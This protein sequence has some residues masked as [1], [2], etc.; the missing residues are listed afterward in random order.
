MLNITIDYEPVP[1]G[2]RGNNGVMNMD[3][4]HAARIWREHGERWRQ[5]YDV[6]IT[7]DTAPVSRIFLEEQRWSD[8]RLIIWVCNRFDYH[9]SPAEHGFPDPGYYDVMGRAGNG[10]L[11]TAVRLVAN[12]EFERRYAAVV[13]VSIR[14]E[15]V[16]PVGLASSEECGGGGSPGLE[17]GWFSRASRR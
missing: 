8:K 12:T 7:S 3:P 5:S 4:A 10:S 14:E 11:G 15:V 16:T 2:G 17:S 1:S 9:S 6:I 13:G